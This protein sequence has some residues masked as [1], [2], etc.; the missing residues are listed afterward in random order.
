[1]AATTW[2]ADEAAEWETALA[3]R[4]KEVACAKC[5]S[6]RVTQSLRGRPYMPYVDWAEAK[7]KELGWKILALSGC[8]QDGNDLCAACGSLAAS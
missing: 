5:G 3:A 2:S 4:M 7:S 1:M 6:D 8:T